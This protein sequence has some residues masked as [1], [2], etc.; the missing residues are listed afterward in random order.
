M[1]APTK[2]A[3]LLVVAALSITVAF[4]ISGGLVERLPDALVAKGTS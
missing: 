4:L 2:S 1:A 3:I